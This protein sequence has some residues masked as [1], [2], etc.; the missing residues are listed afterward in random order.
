MPTQMPNAYALVASGKSTSIENNSNNPL[1]ALAML[2]DC[3]PSAA[4]DAQTHLNGAVAKASSVTKAVSSGAKNSTK[5]A[6]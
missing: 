4:V 5:E 3:L 1:M 2:A 6:P